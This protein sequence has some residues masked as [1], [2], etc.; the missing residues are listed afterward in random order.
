[1]AYKTHIEYFY[2]LVKNHPDK[3]YLRQPFGDNWTE[4]TYRQAYEEAASMASY[5]QSLNLPPK[6]N[7]AILSKNCYHWMLADF[8]IIMSGHISTPFFPNLSAAELSQLLNIGKTEL[9]FIGKLDAPVWETLKDCIPAGLHKVKFPHY[10]GNA[11]VETGTPWNEILKAHTPVETPHVPAIN[12]VWTI[13]FTSGTTGTPKGVILTYNSPAALMDME[14][15]TDTIGI[16]ENKEFIFFSYL[17][18]NHIAERMIVQVASLLTGG[19]VSFGESLE[20]FAKNLQSVQPTVFMSVP[21]I[22]TKFQM[23]VID[24]LGEKKLNFLLKIPF[25]SELL[26]KKIRAGFGLSRAHIILTGAA[27]T[28]QPLKNWY[29]K[30]GLELREIYGMTENAGGCTLMPLNALE[31]GTV[32][33]PLPQVEI[34]IEENTGEVLMRAPWLMEGYFNEP[35]K[36]AAA[37]QNGWL[38]TGDQGELRSDGFLVLTGRVSDTFKT[39]KGKFIAP[40]PLEWK[41]SENILIEQVCVAGL[42]IPQPI[43]LVSLSEVG[44][45]ESRSEVTERLEESLKALNESLP[46]Y[47]HIAKI[48]VIKEEWTVDN[49]L[50]TPTLKIKRNKMNERYE[51][52]YN[53]W[54]NA[55]ETVVWES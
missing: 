6:S 33:K 20:T 52:R 31:P 2:E 29:L 47:Q 45:S 13:L 42:G 1:M 54:F 5:I 19:T 44:K 28:P 23:A 21:R 24:K 53:T 51:D 10:P 4:I 30:L 17:P 12:D 49:G 38:H 3:V 35:E 15:Q 18:L 11:D 50:L 43:A 8:A 34:N 22:Y 27:P 26:K 14:K 25:L 41:L 46:T 55:K 40:G 36:T 32:G 7:I 9:I 37:I 48:V 39:A 16:F